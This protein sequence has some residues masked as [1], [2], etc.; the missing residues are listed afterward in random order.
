MR[1]RT[2]LA[3]LPFVLLGSDYAA[4]QDPSTVTACDTLIATRRIDAASGPAREAPEPGCRRIP[5]GEIGPVEQRALIGGAPYE[6]M[7]I[8]GSSRCLWVV[9]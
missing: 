5:R 6:C 3:A 9:P 4:A 2:L 7:T 1:S 8:T